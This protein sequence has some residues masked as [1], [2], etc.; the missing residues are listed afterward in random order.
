VGLKIVLVLQMAPSRK[1]TIT[2]QNVD[3]ASLSELAGKKL[4][5]YLRLRI[6]RLTVEAAFF[7]V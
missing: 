1:I 7:M 5:L 6:T 4:M 2:K 3:P